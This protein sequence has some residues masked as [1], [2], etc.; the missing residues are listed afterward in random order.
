MRARLL[1]YAAVPD[2]DLLRQGFYAAEASGLRGHPHVGDV[3][4]TNRLAEVACGDYDGLVTFFY[5]YSVVAAL[6]ARLR[7]RPSVAT[8]GAEQ[9]FPDLASTRLRYLARLWAFRAT[10]LFASRVLATSTS[11]L[12]R[13]RKLAW[14]GRSKLSLSFHGAP[15]AERPFAGDG[16]SRSEGSF[17]TI[18]GLDT[19]LNVERKGVPAAIELLAH[20]SRE[21]PSAKLT[22]IGRATC[23]D[24][25]EDQA[26]R[27][28][29]ADRVF[30]TGY[31]DEE[32][33]VALLR[34]HRYYI[35]LSIY[36]GFGI[37]ALEALAQGCQVIHSGVGGLIDS[38]ADFGVVLPRD[39]LEYF[40]LVDLPEY[41]GLADSRLVQH[42]ERFLPATRAAAIMQALFGD[43][44]APLSKPATE[45]AAR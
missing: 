7:G 34:A 18:C 6:L 27:L 1:I 19:P 39:A 12:E 11:D 26:L 22:I 45:A 4:L 20:V 31:V 17:V 32:E 44:V 21:C 23:R 10:V 3:R 13:M 35:Q 24:M 40:T 37:G 43:A 14:F 42:L 28:G 5:S 16:S 36:E 30:I 15:A 33:K 8:G 29:V 9:I 38:I 25:V 41:E 2:G